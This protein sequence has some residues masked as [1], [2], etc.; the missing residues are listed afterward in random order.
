MA[1]VGVGY[2]TAGDVLFE[3][4]MHLAQPCVYTS[5][6]SPVTA[7][8]GVTATV[9][10][11]YAMYPGALLIV[12]LP[13]NTAQEVVTVLTVPTPTTFTA[14]FSNSH[15]AAAPVWGATFPTQQATDPIFTQSEM[16]SYL[17]RAQNEFLTAVPCFYERFFQDVNL[18]MIYQ[19]TPP[20]AILI[21]RIAASFLNIPITTMTRMN[22]VVT[23]TAV[24]PTG[25][26]QYGTFAVANTS[27]DLTDTS[28]LGVFAVS[29]SSVGSGFGGGGYGGGGYGGGSSITYPQAGPDAT[30]TGGTV[31]SMLRL[32]ETTQQE[33]AM[34]NRN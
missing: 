2:R 6:S 29:T 15:L 34:A 10:N 31:Q 5:L 33:L 13:G 20:T 23:L 27:G 24:G 17:S 14:N 9:S 8:A 3:I 11:T 32:Y 30:A 1:T 25:L 4:S 12:E 22:N 7:G 28:F 26:S 18:G 19:A 21:D 16:L